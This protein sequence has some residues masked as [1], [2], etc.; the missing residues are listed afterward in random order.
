MNTLEDTLRA[1]LHETGAEIT[2]QS[3]P[4]LRLHDG[5]RRPG[6]PGT[7]SR[8]RWPAWLAPLA[9]AAAV[10]VV[11]AASLAI[12]ASFHDR[13]RQPPGPATGQPQ[14]APTGRPA[15]LRNVP[16][17]YVALVGKP[18]SRSAEVRATT[19]GAVLATVRPPKPFGLFDWV[20]GASDDRT[21][22]LA[23]QRWWPIGRGGAAEKR[24]NTTPLKFFRLR[25]NPAHGTA[26]LTSVAL[27]ESLEAAQ[28][29]GIGLSPDGSKLALS[30]RQ[31]I[32]VI[33]LATGAK[34]EWVLPG[35]GWAGNFKPFGQPFSWTADGRRLAFQQWGGK[36][37][38]T[39][40][41]RVLDTT[42][43]GGSLLSA[44][45]VVTF[46]NRAGVMTFNPGNTLMTPDGTKIVTA[47]TI[48]PRG[49]SRPEQLAITTFSTRTGKVVASEDRFE[50]MSGWQEV[51]WTSPSGSMLIVTDPRGKQG[52]S[53]TG[54]LTGGRFTP[55]PRAP[56]TNQIAW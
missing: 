27:P 24:D 2:P 3:V 35:G 10:A 48:V 6:R 5:W 42:A 14:G 1:A 49:Q 55:L 12:S 33:T 19:T 41:V 50:M 20:S 18:W 36:F 23:A 9:A 7:G 21:F 44:K 26:T 46:P 51:L 30:L 31:S 53:V 22:I 52:A 39:A 28:V 56:Q 17:Y 40:H 37:H 54:V 47:T 15:A 32:Q 34:R 45:L 25:F 4:P 38:S 16:P 8:R 29:G 13:A 43:P 11:I